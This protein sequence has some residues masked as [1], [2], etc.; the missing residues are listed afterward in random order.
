M[1][2]KTTHGLLAK[3]FKRVPDVVDVLVRPFG[4]RKQTVVSWARPKASDEDLYGTGKG[5]PL[6]RVV[7]LLEELH[8]F[9]PEIAREI[10][11]FFPRIVDELDRRAGFNEADEVEHACTAIA[12]VVES[13]AKLI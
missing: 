8:P 6:D 9:D 12:R 10:G 4:V 11:E 5:N 13:N 2:R 3:A 7:K 1:V